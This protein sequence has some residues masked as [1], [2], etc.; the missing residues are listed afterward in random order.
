MR[1]S[2]SFPSWWAGARPEAGPRVRAG[3]SVPEVGEAAIPIPRRVE[4]VDA[5]WLTRCL[6]ASDLPEGGRVRSLHREPLG[7]GQGFMGETFRLHL[8]FEGAATGAPRSLILKLPSRQRATRAR[9]ELLGLYEREVLFYTELTRE[10]PIALPRCHYAAMDPNPSGP[11]AARKAEQAVADMPVWRLR[12]LLWLGLGLVRLSRRRYVLLLEDLHEGVAGDQLGTST[13][14]QLTRVL[15]EVARM[16]ARFWDSPRILDFPWLPQLDSGAR[17]VRAWY[18]RSRSDFLR[19]FGASLPAPLRFLLDS[20]ESGLPGLLE[21]LSS[22]P[23]TLLHGDLR[24]D[25]LIFDGR[26]EGSRVTFLDWQVPSRGAGVY[27]V[28]YLLSSSL[29][30][31][32]GR[33]EELALLRAYHEA[34]GVNGVRG[35]SFDAC[36][37]DYDR[38]LLLVL[39]RMASS[40]VSVEYTDPRGEALLA[41]WVARMVGRVQHAG[42][43]RLASTLATAAIRRGG[44]SC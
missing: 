41:S 3:D 30:P 31:G 16:H 44:E 6:L 32:V 2:G 24:L 9:A 28:V 10:V 14:A 22:A 34:L 25:N 13:P 23:A 1:P 27:D 18:R 36:I 39:H 38:C 4:E 12:A 15:E 33:E 21:A 43:D 40:L 37:A 8:E 7:E 35:Y 5:A 42:V 17:L 19:R 11:D 29:A 26:G 20:I